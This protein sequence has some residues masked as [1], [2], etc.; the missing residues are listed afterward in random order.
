MTRPPLPHD[1]QRPV[2]AF[3]ATSDSVTEGGMLRPL[4]TLEGGNLSPQLSWSGFPTETKSFAV[5][6]FDP[7][8]PTGSGWWHWVLFDLPAEV[9]GLPAG[10]GSG[11]F[12]GLPPGAIHGRNDYGTKDFGGAA[13][14]PGH[15]L[16]RYVFTVHAL[17]VE[18]LGL[19]DDASAAAIGGTL[20]FFALGRATIC[21]LYENQ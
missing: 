3:A 6:C 12:P 14:P 18:K 11:T 10:A 20:G 15:G 9:T 19:N 13:P 8:A 16:H 21:A 5:T 4:H 17:S 7:D 2:P 1:F